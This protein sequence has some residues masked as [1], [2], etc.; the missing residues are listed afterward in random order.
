MTATTIDD[1]VSR[2]RDHRCYH[3]PIFKH[4]QEAAPGSTAVAALFHQIRSFCDATR[5]GGKFPQ[6]LTMHRLTAESALLQEIVESE[7]NHGAD[8]ATMAGHIVNRAAGRRVFTDVHDQNLVETGLKECSDRILENLPGYDPET[9]L[10]AQTRRARAA[11]DGRRRTDRDATLRNLGTALALEM[12]SNRHLI[13]GWKAALVDSGHYGVTLE[14][15]EMHYLLEHWGEIGA[16]EQHE[17]N[18]I[19]AVAS[20]LNP[21]TEALITEGVDTFLDSLAALWDVLDAALLASGCPAD[22]L[23]SA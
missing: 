9:G 1:L 6:A 18:A 3:H 5:P 17:K 11:F 4:W 16:E 12:I 15:R 23:I 21:T 19:A 2:I 22:D 7:E 8:L 13:P 20:V 10:L 14:S